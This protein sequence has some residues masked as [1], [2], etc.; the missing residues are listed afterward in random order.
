MDNA[1]IIVSSNQLLKYLEN[2]MQFVKGEAKIKVADGE[3][4]IDG[5]RELLVDHRGEMEATVSEVKLRQLR[6]LLKAIT[7]Q[8]LTLHISYDAFFIYHIQV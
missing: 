2:L 1:K 4:Q 8:P 5:F 7:D 6:G 3:L